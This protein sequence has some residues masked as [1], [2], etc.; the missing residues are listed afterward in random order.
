MSLGEKLAA[1]PH[2]RFLPPA[3][4]GCFWTGVQKGDGPLLRGR[5]E[6]WP[7]EISAGTSNIWEG[8]TLLGVWVGDPG[9]VSVPPQDLGVP[10]Q[11]GGY[12]QA[13][14]GVEGG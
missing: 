11:I 12:P 6:K 10:Q 1:L 4:V 14:F 13:P 3:S 7:G 9:T 5:L 2:Q 8:S